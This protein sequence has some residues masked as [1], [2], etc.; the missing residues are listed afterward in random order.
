MQLV[1]AK[2]ENGFEILNLCDLLHNPKGV[3]M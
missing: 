1:P 3:N 2:G